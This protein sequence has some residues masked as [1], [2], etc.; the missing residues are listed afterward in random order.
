MQSFDAIECRT[1]G[2]REV[3][4][5]TR[6]QIGMEVLEIAA[7]QLRERD[8]SIDVVERGDAF[9]GAR[10]PFA[11]CDA[12]PHVRADDDEVGFAHALLE[13]PLE[14]RQRAVQTRGAERWLREIAIGGV[15]GN[16]ALEKQHVVSVRIE[17]ADEAAPGGCV[18]VAPARSDRQAEDDDLHACIRASAAG[19][20]AA[21]PFNIES[22]CC[23]RCAYVCSASTR[24]IAASPI[25]QAR[26]ASSVRT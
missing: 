25:L 9:R 22:T 18:A 17:L 20:A 6:D 5:E 21:T 11:D 24:R 19:A 23:A 8:R 16:V 2:E 26:L 4:I 13:L 7:R 3:E 15:P 1:A 10:Y 14:L 12:L